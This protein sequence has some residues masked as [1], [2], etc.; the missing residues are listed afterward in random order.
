[1]NILPNEGAVATHFTEA[2]FQ[3]DQRP[4]AVSSSSYPLPIFLTLES[5][6]H[7]TLVNSSKR[8][9]LRSDSL[10]SSSA[11][12]HQHLK[13]F[14]RKSHRKRVPFDASRILSSTTATAS[15]DTSDDGRIASE[16]LGSVPIDCI[17]LCEMGS[18]DEKGA[19]RAIAEIMIWPSNGPEG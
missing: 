19:Y 15:E 5:Q 16:A 7:C 2:G 3:G 6:L 4:L 1:M 10:P 8:R 13:S 9:A 18:S 12:Q 11:P 14:S 17:Q